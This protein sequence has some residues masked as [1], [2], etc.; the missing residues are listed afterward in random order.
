MSAATERIG[1]DIRR[2]VRTPPSLSLRIHGRNRTGDRVARLTSDV[3]RVQD[4]LVA[5]FQTVI[6]KALTL[7]GMLTVMF[8]LDETLAVAALV[9]VPLLVVFVVF[10]RPHI[11]AA[12]RRS[13]DLSGVLASRATEILRH[14]RAVQAFSREDEKSERFQADSD[15]AAESAIGAMAITARLS[16][17]ADL[18][19]AVGAGYTLWLGAMGVRSGRLTLGALLVILTYVSSVYGPIVSLTARFDPREGRREPRPPHGRSSRRPR[20]A[21]GP[22][23]A[24]V[25]ERAAADRGGPCQFRLPT[26]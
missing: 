21:R 24:G 6:P 17:V 19:L 1:A 9:V 15:V 2:S 14:V 4:T 5:W 10:S 8:L 3:S 11:K 7:L 12:Q 25:E 16:P 13:R 22:A 23:R 20:S 18:I 26:W